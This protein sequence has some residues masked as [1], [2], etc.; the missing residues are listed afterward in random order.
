MIA[1]AQAGFCCDECYDLWRY[2]R[3]RKTR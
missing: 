3:E 2:G 1:A